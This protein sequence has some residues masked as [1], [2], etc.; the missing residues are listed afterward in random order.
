MNPDPRIEF[1]EKTVSAP[2]LYFRGDVYLYPTR[3]EGIGLTI[4]EALASGLPV[5]T[6]NDAPMNEFVIDGETGYLVDV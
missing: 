3:L 4:C 5:I 1:I 2:G 6:T